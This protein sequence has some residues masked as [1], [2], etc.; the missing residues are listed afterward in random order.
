MLFYLRKKKIYSCLLHFSRLKICSIS[1]PEVAQNI[2]IL[3]SSIQI[4]SA[5]ASLQHWK[6]NICISHSILHQ[7]PNSSYRSSVRTQP[8]M[9]LKKKKK[10]GIKPWSHDL[11]VFHAI[12]LFNPNRRLFS[13]NSAWSGAWNKSPRVI[14]SCNLMAFFSSPLK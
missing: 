9:E 3:F 11:F 8:L 4:P 10:D 12:C 1:S 6:H 13:S 7:Q 2:L 14:T 5:T